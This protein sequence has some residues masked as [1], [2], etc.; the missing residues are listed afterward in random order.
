MPKKLVVHKAVSTNIHGNLE[1]GRKKVW[2]KKLYKQK[3]NHSLEWTVKQN[4]FKKFVEL[5]KQWTE[6]GD[7]ATTGK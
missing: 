4:P 7:G 1:S 3:V 2:Q 5:H 6:A